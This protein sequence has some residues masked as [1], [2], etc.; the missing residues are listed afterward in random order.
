M[1]LYV[2]VGVTSIVTHSEVSI[3]I[4][5]EQT[6]RKG[7]SG[8]IKLKQLL[9]G[10]QKHRQHPPYRHTGHTE[11]TYAEKQKMST[12]EREYKDTS[13]PPTSY[14]RLLRSW[15]SLGGAGLVEKIDCEALEH[16]NDIVLYP[17]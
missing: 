8:Y 12:R 9:S 14:T 6:K 1:V 15:R 16:N 13:W 3:S 4:H 7:Q 10:L 2:C 5:P 11:D 17:F